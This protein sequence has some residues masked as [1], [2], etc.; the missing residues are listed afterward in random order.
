MLK[1]DFWSDAHLEKITSQVCKVFQNLKKTLLGVKTAEE[2]LQDRFKDN[3]KKQS[4]AP[5]T[6]PDYRVFLDLDN[7]F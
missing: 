7:L 2:K 5:Q 4:C 6:E 1:G 3:R